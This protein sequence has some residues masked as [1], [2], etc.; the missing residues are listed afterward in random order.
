VSVVASADEAVVVVAAVV[1]AVVV[2]AVVVAVAVDAVRQSRSHP[3][4]NRIKCVS[5]M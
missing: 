2:A 1:A 4:T 3:A 5:G